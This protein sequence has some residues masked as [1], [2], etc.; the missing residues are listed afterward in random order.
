[1]TKHRFKTF[2]ALLGIA[3]FLNLGFLRACFQFQH[4]KWVRKESEAA[5]PLADKLAKSK[6]G[7]WFALRDIDTLG[8]TTRGWAS[9]ILI[10]TSI[11]GTNERLE[12]IK[13]DVSYDLS[14]RFAAAWLLECRSKGREQLVDMFLIGKQA[15]LE[16]NRVVML[17]CCMDLYMILKD[18]RVFADTVDG[19]LQVFKM[20]VDEFQSILSQYEGHGHQGT[21]H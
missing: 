18:D 3:C 4:L 1:M 5:A 12:A 14:K 19:A 15:A 20:S 10:D 7:V 11:P 17:Y 13:D 6:Y 9:K 21:G 8:G 2:F 16:T